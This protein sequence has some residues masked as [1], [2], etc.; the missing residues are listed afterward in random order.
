MPPARK[1]TLPGRPLKPG[2]ALP[3]PVLQPAPTWRAPK[4]GEIPRACLRLR[5]EP[6]L[7]DCWLEQFPRVANAII[8]WRP[9]G[10]D[11]NPHI[12]WPDWTA[13]HKLQ[14]RRAWMH[15]RDWHANGMTGFRGTRFQDPPPNQDAMPDDA[16]FFRTVL[17][18]PT[19]AWPWFLAQVA[20]SLAAEI[21]GWFPWS[22]RAYSTEHLEHLF[23][24]PLMFTRDTDNGGHFDTDHPGGF[25]IGGYAG[26]EKATPSHPTYVYRF[27]VEQD[28]LRRT[29]IHTI[30]R[31]LD[32]C[33][34][35]MHHYFGS[36]TPA[37]A[38]FHWQYRGRP[39][40]RRIIDKTPLTNPEMGGF[41]EPRSWTAGCWGT[42]AFLRSVLR[43]VNIPVLGVT[44]CG[45]T[46]PHF[47]GVNRYLSHGDDPYNGLAKA[48]YPARELLI[49][50]AT[51]DAWFP[52]D[53]NDPNNADDLAVG[54]PNVGRRVR[55]L[56]IW[57]VSAN[58][59]D[60]YCADKA[61]GASHADG[62]V[63]EIFARDGHTVDELE[64]AGLWDRLE[65][66]AQAQGTC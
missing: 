15:A 17:D 54:C 66:E 49:D 6:E 65:A 7:L 21:E 36:F 1:P 64:A 52:W 42:T 56:A 45:H 27:L 29:R 8:W 34:A 50:Q 9:Q 31:L 28:V 60:L 18:G 46:M 55:E 5:N 11:G 40:V 35:N 38:D 51:F 43:T 10:A 13:L 4:P 48:G 14:L 25:T 16:P 53:A 12:A 2:R 62:Q 30:G 63:F 24:G 41:E 58:L 3:R 44:R 32:W 47:A 61:A 23:A 59:L 37:N 20:H 19:Q 57:H 39:P 33:R 26:M 22:I